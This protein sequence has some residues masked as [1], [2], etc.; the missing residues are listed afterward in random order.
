ML[1]CEAFLIY[2]VQNRW[3]MDNKKLLGKRIK[4]LR[5][6][7]GLT[8]EKVAEIISVETTSLSEM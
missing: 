8:Q 2:N 1:I 3:N 4:E 6:N 5:K 7:L